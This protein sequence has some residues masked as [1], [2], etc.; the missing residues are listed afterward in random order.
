MTE[1]AQE[2]VALPT[3]RTC[4][5]APPEE[6]A[7]PG[8]RSPVGRLTYPDGTLGR[9]VTGY[10]QA[11]SV[12]G[13]PSFSSRSELQRL[14]VPHPWVA[15]PAAP[16]RFISMD[17]PDRTRLCKPPAGLFTVRR[18]NR[19]LPRVEEIT[20]ERLDVPLRS[21]M[22]VHGVHELPVTW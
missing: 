10:A 17:P 14:P 2:P 21:E 4:P 5:F 22:I 8:S 13:N 3:A 18:T 20:R 12:L 15:E 9:L 11:R 6:L 19:L 7:T 16:G 1:T